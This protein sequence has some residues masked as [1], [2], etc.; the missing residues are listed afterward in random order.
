[1]IFLKL[2]NLALIGNRYATPPHNATPPPSIS[3]GLLGKMTPLHNA[4]YGGGGV[5]EGG[6]AAM[7]AA[8][9]FD[10]LK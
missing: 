1:M 2:A 4:G 7:S 3:S 5:E 6:G 10:Y 8:L 9:E